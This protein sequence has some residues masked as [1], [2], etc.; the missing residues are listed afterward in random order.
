M[1][2]PHAHKT[3]IVIDHSPHFSESC[4]QAIEFDVLFNKNRT[5]GIIPLAPVMK[6]MWTCN[7]EAV[8]E[9][10][11]IVYDVF[12]KNKL[13]RLISSDSAANTMNTWKQQEQLL[14]HLLVLFS[15]IKPPLAKS[16]K[17]DFNIMHGL[18][19][20]IEVLCETSE[21]QHRM[22]TSLSPDDSAVVNRGRVICLTTLKSDAH[23]R[24]IEECVQDTIVQ[25]NKLAAS[26]DSL[27]PIDHCELVLLHIVPVGDDS[28]VTGRTRKEISPLL[29]SEVHVTQSGKF[30]ALKL[31]ELVQ[32]HYDL[33]STT[34]TGI[35]MKEE[36]N[37]SSSANYDVELLHSADAHREIMKSDHQEGVVIQSKEGLPTMTVG[38]KWCTPKSNVIELQNCLGAY[39][40]TPVDVNSRPSQCLTN[41]LLS[42]RA[43]MLEQPRK[44]GRVMSHMLA[45][46]GGELYIHVLSIARSALEDPPSISEGAGG[47]VTDYRIQDFGDFMKENRL[48][49]SKAGVSAV[50][51]IEIAKTQL[52]RMTRHWPIVISNTIIFNMVSHLDPLPSLIMKEALEEEE[53]LECKKA[54]YHVVGMES[55]N[56]PLPVPTLG[57]RGKGPKRDEQYRQMWNELEMFIRGHAGTSA[58]HNEVLKCLLDCKRP[59]EGKGSSSSPVK[60]KEEKAD[61]SR[62]AEAALR[63][64]EK[65]QKMSEREKQ[66][67]NKVEIKDSPDSPPPVKQQK[68]STIGK[69]TPGPQS[70]LSLWANRLKSQSTKRHKEFDGR[71]ESDGPQ[72]ELYIHLKEEL[73]GNTPDGNF[74]QNKGTAAAKLKTS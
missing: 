52:E 13:I 40:V 60:V 1:A 11:R 71:L 43:V 33:F 65:Y 3:V 46:H 20:A 16:R 57:T 44:T 12:P 62:Q 50:K 47:R 15:A 6:S 25:H 58:N 42:G 29:T 5:S 68:M 31:M 34:V 54:I 37:A 72:A 70:L 74:P 22:R 26:S 39:R 49:P 36:Q 61:P 56:D 24:T 69:V 41:F 28:A 48:A 64:Y 8:L 14:N 73:Q 63:D 38:L 51:P 19:R 18:V 21:L 53:V 30:I 4:K 2:F 35:P 55:R 59:E 7:V 66:D 23:V 45:S 67:L 10:C 27:I 17:A 9:Y 32:K